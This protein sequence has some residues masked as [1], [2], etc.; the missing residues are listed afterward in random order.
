MGKLQAA[1]PGFRPVLFHSP[2][3]AAAW[4]IVATRRPASQARQVR[5]NIAEE[6]GAVFDL[7]GERAAAFPT[8]ERLADIQA[9]PGV[10]PRRVERLRA[11][12]SAAMDGRLD[13]V[14]LAAR[15]PEEAAASV[16][17]IPGIGEFYSGLIAY[18]SVG[19][20][21]SLNA[22]DP[23]SLRCAEHFYSLAQTPTPDE[24][25]ARADRWR[26][27]RSWAAVLLRQAGFRDGITS[28]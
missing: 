20:V 26:P 10:D 1:Y 6:L 22:R 9:M 5:R 2:Y 21:D 25:R 14:A 15:G 16:R 19:F 8:P 4:A 11:V 23:S 3:E 13:A 7:E 24:F 18:R 28:R 17:A 12:A 27:F